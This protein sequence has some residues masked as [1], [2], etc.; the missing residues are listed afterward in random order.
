MKIAKNIFYALGLIL[1]IAS[2]GVYFLPDSYTVTES[3]EIN[4][5]EKTIYS[6][7]SD[8][9]NWKNWSPW[10]EMEP[11]AL[12]TVT[13]E[14]GKPGH[15]LSWNGKKLG[16]GSLSIRIAASNGFLNGDLVFE[17]PFKATAKD[18][19]SFEEK[20]N[21]TI[22]TWTSTGGL[23]FPFGRLYGLTMNETLSKQQKHGL[24]KLKNLCESLP[25]TDS[26][27]EQADSI[28]V[29]P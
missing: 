28:P 9:N 11:N 22:V 27:A 19:W 3:I 24:E 14:P 4:R 29:T 10:A 15:Q 16:K 12:F 25:D 6:M 13:G 17:E 2:V 5:P 23:S 21:K 18:D 20:D 8:Y 26:L 1:V 7:V